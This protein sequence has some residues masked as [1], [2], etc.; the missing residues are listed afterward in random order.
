MTENEVE[1]RITTIREV[2]SQNLKNT[3][4]YLEFLREI[5]DKELEENRQEFRNDVINRG[6]PF[7]LK[8]MRW[9]IDTAIES[10][11][12][13]KA[14]CSSFDWDSKD[15]EKLHEQLLEITKNSPSFH[16]THVKIQT[17]CEVFDEKTIFSEFRESWEKINYETYRTLDSVADLPPLH[18][19]KQKADWNDEMKFQNERITNNTMDKQITFSDVWYEL[20]QS[21]ENQIFES[22]LLGKLKQEDI[23]LL[24]SGNSLIS[25][26][27]KEKA[28]NLFQEF[29]AQKT[30]TSKLIEALKMQGYS[31]A[32]KL[33]EMVDDPDEY[34]EEIDEQR[35]NKIGTN[36]YAV[37]KEMVLEI[38][39][40]YA[41]NRGIS[42]EEAEITIKEGGG[43]GAIA[44]VLDYYGAYVGDVLVQTSFGSSDVLAIG[45]Q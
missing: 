9:D 15:K 30:S 32:K 42:I 21:K 37:T 26:E 2:I 31:K 17:I 20:Q 16:T 35:V 4:R 18:N 7:S 41:K 3:E 6:L 33:W 19:N 24:R 23:D 10:L 45:V 25:D 8:S 44:D 27:L 12:K 28:I 14:L 1:N 11:E 38:A 43:N 34:F 39:P 36:S 40:E 29:T 5:D 22:Y 13:W